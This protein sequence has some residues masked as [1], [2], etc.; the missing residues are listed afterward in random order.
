MIWTADYLG[1]WSIQISLYFWDP[2]LSRLSSVTREAVPDLQR[3]RQY[4]VPTFSLLLIFNDPFWDFI[5]RW[6]ECNDV[7]LWIQN[8]FKNGL[9]LDA[10]ND[11]RHPCLKTKWKSKKWICF[12]VDFLRCGFFMSFGSN[13][14]FTNYCYKE[15]L[16]RK[17]NTC[18]LILISKCA[19]YTRTLKRFY[20]RATRLQKNYWKRSRLFLFCC[21]VS[22]PAPFT[23]LH[24]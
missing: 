17:F 10:L 12:Q 8:K 3:R 9:N 4:F 22:K 1:C 13:I 24:S 6:D 23:F 5:W 11:S 14:I 19:L 21:F 20:I 16:E 7:G 18:N 15:I 2:V